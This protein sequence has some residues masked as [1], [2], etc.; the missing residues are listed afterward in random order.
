MNEVG[1]QAAGVVGSLRMGEGRGAPHE[2]GQ[3]VVSLA[4]VGAPSKMSTRVTPCDC[5]M[6]ACCNNCRANKQTAR[7][8]VEH[9]ALRERVSEPY[10]QPYVAVH[11]QRPTSGNGI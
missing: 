1:G 5:S 8:F 3:S 7:G 11:T 10:V 6:R 2:P 4:G 9:D